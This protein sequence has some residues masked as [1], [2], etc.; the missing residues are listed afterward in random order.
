MD[1]RGGGVAGAVQ[2]TEHGSGEKVALTVRQTGLWW[3]DLLRAD[4]RRMET[5]GPET[6]VAKSYAYA[7]DRGGD[8]EHFH[9]VWGPRGD[10]VQY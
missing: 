1:A 7:M 2:V 3:Y 5:A 4:T 9:H 8:R 6:E 10:T